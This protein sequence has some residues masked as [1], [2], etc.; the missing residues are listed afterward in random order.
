MTI[1][2][3]KATATGQQITQHRGRYFSWVSP[4]GWKASETMNGLTLTAPN[5]SDSVMYAILLRSQGQSNPSRFLQW[6][7]SHMPGYSN[8]KVV[9][10]RQ[11]PDQRSGIQG[12]S[13]KVME[14]EMNYTINGIP[15]R[16]VW[17]CGVNNYYGMFDASVNGYHASLNAWQNSRVYLQSM[18]NRIII[19]NPRQIA[20]NDTL[21]PVKNNPLDNSGIIESGRMRDASRDR[22]SK[23][24]R[25]ATMGQ[26]R[27]KD[28]Y[29][30]KIYNMPNTA[31]DPAVGGYRNPN[32]P[33]E[34][35][36]PTKP[37]E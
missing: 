25:E 4:I 34:L 5:G 7:L 3:S 19:T 14:I 8:F 22:I 26:E 30:G 24:Q 11:L 10:T 36:T 9:S 37:G 20:G 28:P 15:H 32:R 18:S 29:T 12:T 13:W 6:M 2:V 23:K 1:T 21:I 27:M 35:L 17:T 16:G 33:G 31:Y